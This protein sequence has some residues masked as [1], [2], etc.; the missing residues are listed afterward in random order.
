[1]RPCP[2]VAMGSPSHHLPCAL[3]VL[4]LGL[5]LGGCYSMTA[6]GQVSSDGSEDTAGDDDDDTGDDDTAGDDD[7]TQPPPVDSDGDGWTEDQDCDDSDPD[8][9][10][11]STDT[12]DG[13]DSDCDGNLDWLVTLYVAV[14]DAGVLCIDG[15]DNT[16][17]DT[18]GWPTGQQYEIW[19]ES[20][21]HAAGIQGWDTG[22]V[23]TAGIA[24]IE[25][26]DG[27]QWV[28]D[29]SWRYDPNP[30]ATEDSRAGWCSPL[31]DDSSWDLVN[32]IG[33]I[34][35]SPWGG[36]PSSFPTGSPANWIWDHYPVDLNTQYLRKE[37]TLP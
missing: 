25:I 23:I 26:S 33:P 9:N 21:T 37:F 32:V 27:T 8:V 15:T 13:Q 30:T 28:S 18:G 14:D 10:P 34:G 31:F 35:T 36:A 12:V 11:D 7:T 24:H 3:S 29:A 16:L 2:D 22:Q 6:R 17:G 5:V 1:M 20:G 4:A 19:L